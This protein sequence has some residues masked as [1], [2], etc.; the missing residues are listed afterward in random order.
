MISHSQTEQQKCRG[1]KQIQQLELPG[2][3]DPFSVSGVGKAQRDQQRG[4]G[5]VEHVGKSIAEG[6]GQHAQL[7]RNRKDLSQRGDQ[8][9]QQ[10]SLGGAGAD[11]EVHHQ[12]QQI[13]KQNH[14]PSGHI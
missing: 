3:F 12:H 9:H 5:G 10:K 1:Q 7:G 13:D 2:V 6:E 11:E 14:D 4:I 8:R